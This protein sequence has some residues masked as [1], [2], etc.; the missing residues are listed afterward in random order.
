MRR[1]NFFKKIQ[2]GL[3]RIFKTRVL[4]G[5]NFKY[6]AV[7]I[8]KYF[9]IILPFL[10]D[11]IEKLIQADYLTSNFIIK[12]N[13]GKFCLSSQ[14]DTFGKSSEFFEDELN[15]WLQLPQKKDLFIDIGANIGFYSILAINKFEYDRSISFEA[16][17]DTFNILE[18]NIT[19]NNIQDKVNLNNYGLG[20]KEDSL[21]FLKKEVHT[22]GSRF[23]KKG[24]KNKIKQKEISSVSKIPVK[25]GDRTLV[26]KDIKPR[27]I[28]MIKIDV[29]GHEFKVIKGMQKILLNMKPNSYL[30]VEIWDSNYDEV[31]SIIEN[32]GFTR[33]DSLGS[34]YLFRK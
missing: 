1:K 21:N 14:N 7:L 23:I 25:K 18:K 28:S 34:N 22:G 20:K 24:E 6:R 2:H 30:F 27:K 19:L 9:Q 31:N 11:Y 10:S 32:L 5:G 33:V 3:I 17:P 12:N 13:L 8:L 4:E 29:E 16:N 15:K 26:D